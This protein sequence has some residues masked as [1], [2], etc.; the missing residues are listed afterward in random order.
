VIDKQEATSVKL[1]ELMKIM[2]AMA[3]A[4]EGTR[5]SARRSQPEEEDVQQREPEGRRRFGRG[6]RLVVLVIE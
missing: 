6:V 3:A 1:D 2:A 5:G 4:G